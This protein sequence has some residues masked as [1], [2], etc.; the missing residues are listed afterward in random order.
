MTT[1]FRPHRLSLRTISLVIL[2]AFCYLYIGSTSFGHYHVVDGKKVMHSHPYSAHHQHG[3][4]SQVFT[5]AQMGGTLATPPVPFMLSVLQSFVVI[6]WQIFPEKCFSV[7]ELL[8]PIPR[9]PPFSLMNRWWNFFEPDNGVFYKLWNKK[10][11]K[12]STDAL[13]ASRCFRAPSCRFLR[14]HSPL[15]ASSFMEKVH[16][17]CF[18]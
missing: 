13:V 18:K 12:E 6:Q 8:H 2:C 4:A 10:R 15:C 5:F 3:N 16:L 9:A 7:A 1:S 14:S 17:C 11:S